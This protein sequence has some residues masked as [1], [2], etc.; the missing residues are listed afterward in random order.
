MPKS[1]TNT[2]RSRIGF[3]ILIIDCVGK[4]WNPYR[5]SIISFEQQTNKGSQPSDGFSAKRGSKI[6]DM[7]IYSK[8][9]Q[10]HCRI[11]GGSTIKIR[12]TYT[13]SSYHEE[14]NKAYGIDVN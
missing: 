13:C 14:L 8:E 7:D 12:A 11:C 9:L 1:A 6:V 2:M 3:R 5:L 10:Q 4:R